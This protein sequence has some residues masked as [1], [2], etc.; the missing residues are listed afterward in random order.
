MQVPAMPH[1]S[2]P[3]GQPAVHTLLTHW[4]PGPQRMPQP[5]QSFGLLVVSTQ[6]LPHIVVPVPQEQ[7]LPEHVAPL[8]QALPQPPQFCGSSVSLTQAPLQLVRPVPQLVVHMPAEH[9][10]I[11]VHLVP[12]PPQLFGSLWV[13]VQT[14][15]QRVPLLS[16]AQTPAVQLVPAPHTVPQ[17]PQLAL[18]VCSFTHALPHWV[19]PAVQLSVQVPF[20]HT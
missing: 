9:T 15:A 14:P 17:A 18:S 20:A 4:L 16:Q 19:S 11:A 10:C 12:Q 1:D 5:P 6:V 13:A 8:G 7:V 3:V 2:S